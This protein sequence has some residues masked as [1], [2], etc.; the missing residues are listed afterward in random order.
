MKRILHCNDKNKKTYILYKH[1]MI[2]KQ[3]YSNLIDILNI[4]QVYLDTHLM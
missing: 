2:I 3:V 1:V 4:K